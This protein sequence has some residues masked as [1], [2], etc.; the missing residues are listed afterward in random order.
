MNSAGD[1]SSKSKLTPVVKD[2]YL[3]WKAGRHSV[4][5]GISGTP[6]WGLIEKI[7]G[8]RSVEKTPLDL[9]KYAS[10]RDFGAAFKGSLD[11]NKKVNYHLMISNGASNGSENNDG[12]KGMLALSAAVG[13]GIVV[14]GYVD[15]EERPGDSNRY[16]LQGFAAYQ[17]KTAKIGVQF[18]HQNRQ[19]TGSDVT[20]QV[21]SAFAT[22]K[23]LEKIWGFTRVDRLLDAN[24]D[25]AKISYIP[26][27]KTAKSTFFVGGIDFR[28]AKDIHF[29]PNVEVIRYD[30]TGNGVSPDTD[31]IPRF[32]F[33]YKF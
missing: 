10:S 29:M 6:T 20:L 27:E 15:Y 14:E 21:A 7:W 26:F 24:P 13:N 1:F 4:I 8:Y 18:A 25:G 22:G 16:T 9:H 5:L 31:I 28:P 23:L 30:E 3:K 33:Y 17:A 19:T 12:K 32:S 2:A 11:Q